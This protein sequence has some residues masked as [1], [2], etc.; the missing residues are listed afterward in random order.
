MHSTKQR[1]VYRILHWLVAYREIIEETHT[2]IEIC[3]YC[4]R[5]A[6]CNLCP[7]LHRLLN[8]VGSTRAR[9]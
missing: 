9:R 5:Y 7:N 6:N 3:D 8:D 4:S 2:A 1:L